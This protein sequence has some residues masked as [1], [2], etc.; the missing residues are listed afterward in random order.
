M[1]DAGTAESAA[2]SQKPFEKGVVVKV[3]L[4]QS[5]IPQVSSAILEIDPAIQTERVPRNSLIVRRI[6]DGADS[7]GKS[8]MLA[9]PFFSSHIEMPV[10][11]GETVWLMFDK[12]VR[13]TGYWMSRIHGD[14]SSEDVNY[15]HYDRGVI[16]K[17]DPVSTVGTAEKAKGVSTSVKAP[18]PEDFPNFSL[19]QDKGGK[20]E[21]ARILDEGGVTPHLYEP[22][23]RMVKR[24]GD[25]VIQGSNNALIALTTDRGWKKEDQPAAAQSNAFDVPVS[26]SGAIDA[27]VGRGRWLSKNEKTRTTPDIM[28]N[29][30]G[31]IETTKDIRKRT[32]TVLSEGD[33]DFFDDAARVYIT[34]NS[35]IDDRLSLK[36]FLPNVPGERSTDAYSSPDTMNSAVAVKA[37]IVRIVSRKDDAHQINGSISIIKEGEKSSDGDHCAIS[38]LSTGDVLLSGRRVFLGRAKSDGGKGDGP[39]DAPGQSQPY[40]KYEQL[41]DVLDGMINDITA[42]CASLGST[43]P[44]TLGPTSALTA[45]LVARKLAIPKM[46][47]DRIFGE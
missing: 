15:S 27:V 9:Y 29:S 13:T 17:A 14:D 11:A 19:K 23:P 25:L 4:D 44:P 7:A 30:R 8:L 34:M 22:V 38:L 28:T 20:N 31:Y 46:K 3:I 40:V 6:T 45:K 32:T 41:K 26:F 1:K 36:D 18:P 39:N 42:F 10:K 24:P 35:K 43:L 2:A 47:S 5:Q 33:P 12:D 16:P 21:Y 37:D